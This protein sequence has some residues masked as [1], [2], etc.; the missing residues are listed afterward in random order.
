MSVDRILQHVAEDSPFGE[1]CSLSR[2]LG[3]AVA[4]PRLVHVLLM[5]T[6]IQL[7]HEKHSCF[8][9]SWNNTLID[10]VSFLSND[11][12][13]ETITTVFRGTLWRC[14]IFAAAERCAQDFLLDCWFS[15]SSFDIGYQP[16][17]RLRWL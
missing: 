8:L 1:I 9:D 5:L 13:T 12:L 10:S 11:E 17:F 4:L 15:V 2:I 3:D 7:N 14:S 6:D 16:H